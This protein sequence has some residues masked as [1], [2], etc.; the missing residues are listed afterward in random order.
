[1]LI[2][3]Y[4]GFLEE[5]PSHASN[6]K[7]TFLE[8]RIRDAAYEAEDT[9]DL[10]LSNLCTE[11]MIWQMEIEPMMKQ[12]DSLIGE[13][14]EIKEHMELEI[15]TVKC[16]LKE[17]EIK[18]CEEPPNALRED[19]S[20]STKNLMVGFGEYL[21][22][23]KDQ[24][25]GQ[26]S[27]LEVI[28]IV[29][30]GGIGKT[31][32]A[33]HAYHDPYVVHQFD[34]HIW[35]TVSQSYSIRDIMSSMLASMNILPKSAQLGL[36]VYQNLKGRRYLIIID[37]IWDIRVFDEL[38]RMF[39]D[40]ETGSRIMLT[41]RIANVAA[42]ASPS[43]TLHQISLL[44]IVHSWEL[45]CAKVF[46][47]EPCP[48]NLQE[49]G[50]TVAKNC[51]GLPLSI[52]VIGGL[53]SKV[54]KTPMV[55]QSVA[56]NVTSLMFSGDDQCSEILRL[57]YN[58]LPRYLKACFLYMAI[59]PKGHE[60]RVSKLVKMWV[61]EG[62]LRQV[63]GQ[64][65]EEVAERCVE[66]LLDRSLILRSKNSEGKIRAF[67]IH[68]L[69]LDFCVKEA[70]H[71]KF[72]QI[73]E[74]PTD[75][76]PTIL[77]SERRI[78]ILRVEKLVHSPFHFDSISSTN[79]YVRTFVSVDQSYIYFNLFL[80]FKLL[81]VLDASQVWFGYFPPQVLELVNL[82]YM[83]LLC[84]GDI[85]ASITKLWNLQTLIIFRSCYQKISDLPAEIWIMTHLRHVRC[86]GTQLL[87]PTAAKFDFVKKHI[88]LENLQTLSGLWNLEFSKEML[89]SIPNIK[90]IS[91][92]YDLSSLIGNEWSDYQL[93]NLGN[94]N[95]LEA[96]KI[97]VI[98]ELTRY[99]NLKYRSK[100][101]FQFP[102]SLKTLTLGG[103]KIAWHDLAIVGSLPNL[104]VLKLKDLACV[105]TEWE[106]NE[107]EFRELKVLVL[108]ELD[109]KHW[110]AD[111]NHFP[112]LQRLIIRWCHELV[113]IPSGMGE[114]ATLTTIG[115]CM[116]KASVLASANEILE[117]Q[118]SYGNDDFRVINVDPKI[119]CRPSLSLA[120]FRFHEAWL[121]RSDVEMDYF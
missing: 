93:E 69:L 63:H 70:K 72:L 33:T 2:Y 104:E 83:A 26:S 73:T 108:E 19:S 115:L 15:K 18:T 29:G 101:R 58:Y 106:P 88:F 56:D 102:R 67:R 65:A 118:L 100:F 79:S 95:Q 46:G 25:I 78:S 28:S 37:D 27:A 105:G 121:A 117:K 114:S 13:V 42:Y 112:S 51:Q 59:F 44:S 40:D 107:N 24:L 86:E 68:D 48:S 10:H 6:E 35:V 36:D 71:E 52:V 113:E 47:D 55:W 119:K 76:F 90:K 41:T 45:L 16:S 92:L 81:K 85:P 77:A 111:S 61:A 8:R 30:M 39:P 43:G 75:L 98:P 110:K 116:C 20:S 74:S 53:L 9:M 94:L 21:M 84:D 87:C 1:M 38:K 17:A 97:C 12:V 82:R 23:I 5:H 66:E 120:I 80:R 3:L 89:R 34:V 57:S 91:V 50:K 11:E 99:V 22:H 32:L 31:T 96:L 7:V 109:L 4:A 49:I 54:L 60:I 64:V 14:T 62:F 103:V